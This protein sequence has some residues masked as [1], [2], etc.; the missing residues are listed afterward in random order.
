MTITQ[1]FWLVLMMLLEVKE[2][3]IRRHNIMI[4]IVVVVILIVVIK[5]VVIVIAIFI[6]GGKL[7]ARY[8]CSLAFI[9]QY[10]YYINQHVVW[11]RLGPSRICFYQSPHCNASELE[12]KQGRSK[13]SS[14]WP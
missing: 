3:A 12:P 8:C 10:Q 13:Q 2:S 1:M 11:T 14:V 5:I 6:P 9:G 4:I 7:Q